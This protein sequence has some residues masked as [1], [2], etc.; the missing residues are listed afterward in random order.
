MAESSCT[1][2]KAGTLQTM[3]MKTSLT[4]QQYVRTACSRQATHHTFRARTTCLTAPEKAALS[5]MW[6]K[7]SK[8][9]PQAAT[10]AVAL[11]AP[12]AAG[13]YTTRRDQCGAMCTGT[14]RTLLVKM[15]TFC[16]YR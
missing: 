5:T 3:A 13:W 1:G 8:C 2:C 15:S 10:R 11:R 6:G 9:S 4:E 7:L 16:K 12:I 14:T